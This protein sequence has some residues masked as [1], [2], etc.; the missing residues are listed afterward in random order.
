MFDLSRVDDRHCLESSMWM[1]PNSRTITILLL[2]YTPWSIVIE[3]DK[4]TGDI[5]FH[6]FPVSWQVIR[7]TKPI[8]YHMHMPRMFCSDY[9]LIVHKYIK[10]L[11]S[12]DLYQRS[13]LMR[14]SRIY[15]QLSYLSKKCF[16]RES[17]L[18]TWS[19]CSCTVSDREH[20]YSLL[21]RR[22]SED[23]TNSTRIKSF[24]ST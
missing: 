24:H 12:L 20:H 1:K 4:R 21:C 8:T 13:P 19:L 17:E 10:N 6:S 23:L 22:E 5:I 16:T 9:C 15:E 14:A 18:R 7:N 3:H 2:W 11:K